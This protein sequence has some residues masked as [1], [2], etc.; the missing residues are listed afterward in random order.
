MSAALLVLAAT[1]SGGATH[2]QRVYVPEGWYQ[3][4]EGEGENDAE[5]IAV[6]VVDDGP[7]AA[8]EAAASAPGAPGAPEPQDLAAEVARFQQPDCEHVRGS[9]LSRILELHGVDAF[10]LDTAALSAWTR[11]PPPPGWGWLYNGTFGDP[12]LAPLWGA[13]PTPPGALSFDF[14]LQLRARDLL[15]CQTEAPAAP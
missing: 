1:L 9:Y 5:E 4:E 12:A 3:L 7:E 6:V 15:R 13:P 10:A 8:V 14:E 2:P 11:Q